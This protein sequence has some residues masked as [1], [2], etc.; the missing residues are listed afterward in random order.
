MSTCTSR[1]QDT[2]T[3]DSHPVRSSW[4]SESGN[5][6]TGPRLDSVAVIGRKAVGP[7]QGPATLKQAIAGGIAVL[8]LGLAL[9]S[10]TA[11]GANGDIQAQCGVVKSY[12]PP[13]AGAAGTVVIGSRSFQVQRQS[14]VAVGANACLTGAVLVGYIFDGFTAGPIP[15]QTCGTVN[16]VFPANAHAAGSISIGRDPEF[17]LKLSAGSV[18]SASVQGAPG[19]ATI[20]LDAAGDAVALELS[21]SPRAGAL[22]STGTSATGGSLFGIVAIAAASVA[23]MGLLVGWYRRKTVT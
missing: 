18:T 14:A 20:G 12:S 7:A 11:A 4:G 21:E 23:G 8:L 16:G 13:T 3:A 9:S 19:C 10:E 2:C 1:G 15:A 5:W 17:V 22:P 6:N